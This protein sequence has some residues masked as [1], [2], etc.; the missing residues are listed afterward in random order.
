MKHPMLKRIKRWY[1]G[2][3]IIESGTLVGDT[4]SPIWPSAYR[5]YHWTATT[6]RFAAKAIKRRGGYVLVVLSGLAS[7]VAIADYA[8]K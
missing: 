3:W 6:V 4:A 5:E 2:E 8:F 1:V 7:C